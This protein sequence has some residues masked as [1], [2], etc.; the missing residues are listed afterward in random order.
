MAEIFCILM[1]SITIIGLIIIVIL[2]S[3]GM[4]IPY[5][6]TILLP[7]FLSGAV[8]YLTNFIAVKMLF[9]PY[10]RSDRH[11]IRYITFGL[12]KQG[13]IPANKN[14]IGEQMA[15]EISTRY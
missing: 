4:T 14:K 3:M 12:W 2:K 7:F 5:Y 9:E 11:W 6:I 15:E 13:M 1:S 10:D 8:G